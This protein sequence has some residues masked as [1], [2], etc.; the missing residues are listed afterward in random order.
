MNVFPMALTAAVSLLFGV[1]VWLVHAS[2]VRRRAA[3]RARAR[4][5]PRRIHL[6]DGDDVV[7]QKLAVWGLHHEVLDQQFVGRVR[8]SAAGRDQALNEFWRQARERAVELN[9]GRAWSLRS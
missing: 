9:G 7:V 4:W 2:S 8:G 1:C 3:A 5:A 6:A